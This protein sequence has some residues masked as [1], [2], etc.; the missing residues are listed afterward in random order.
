MKRPN[1]LLSLVCWLLPASNFKN[2]L[3]RMLG[4]KIG[5][6]VRLGPN[7]VVGCGAFEVGDE[8]IVSSLNVFR[9]LARVELGTKTFIGGFNQFT[10]AP[11]YQ[12][13]HDW[14]GVLVLEEQA[15]ITNRH[16]FDASGRIEMRRYSGIGGIRSIFQSHEIDLVE[17][18]T[19]VGT[20]ELGE[21][22]MTATACLV[23]KG[24]R[25]P[26]WSVVAAGSTVT[27]ARGDDELKPGV[28]AGSPARWRKE[29]PDCKW[30]HRDGYFT[31]V[32][33]AEGP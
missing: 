12:L 31:P 9:N 28:Y 30:W 25:I 24:A 13:I 19:T 26:G 5:N 4:N 32:I 33:P 11:A 23:L 1:K 17:N 20:V 10:A 29:L 16:Y 6:G 15:I 18:R 7:V 27:A 3:L 22:A 14:A 21:R 2:R 8:A